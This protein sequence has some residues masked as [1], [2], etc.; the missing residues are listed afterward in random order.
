MQ[1]VD[2]QGITK[3]LNITKCL[4][5]KH[6]VMLSCLGGLPA[7]AVGSPVLFLAPTL[8]LVQ[9]LV[10]KSLK[11]SLELSPYS[12]PKSSPWSSPESSFCT[13]PMET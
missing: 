9:A 4:K 2:L 11:M 7:A 8:L 10:A 12:S 13:H 1:L 5:F 6:L 3:C